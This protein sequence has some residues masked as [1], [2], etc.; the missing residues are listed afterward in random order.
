MRHA[1]SDYDRIQDPAATNPLVVAHGT[2]IGQDEP[3]FIIRARDIVAPETVRAWAV[4][5]RDAGADLALVALAERWADEMEEWQMAHG[6]HVPDV[7]A[8]V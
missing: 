8:G 6:A 7:P 2:P 5:A 4:L 3:V 1:R